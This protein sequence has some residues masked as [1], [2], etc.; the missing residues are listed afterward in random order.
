ML[1]LSQSMVAILHNV[2]ERAR[3]GLGHI[4]LGET[5]VGTRHGKR[6]G[7]KHVGSAVSCVSEC[8]CAWVSSSAFKC[9]R[10]RSSV[11]EG[12]SVGQN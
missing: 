10:V 6:M 5:H 11:W 4:F 2:C 8:P 3:G 1:S 9:V 7:I 12:D